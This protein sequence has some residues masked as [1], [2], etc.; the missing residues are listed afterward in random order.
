MSLGTGI[1]LSTL[2]IA[3]VALYG[4]TKD[5]WNWRRFVKRSVFVCFGMVLLGGMAGGAVYFYRQLPTVVGRQTEYA[6]LRLGM[7]RDEVLYVNGYP[8][9]VLAD[10][11]D[12]A[13]TGFYVVV[14]TS[15]LE[16]GKTIH[17]YSRW[18][19]AG[20]NHNINVAFN[21]AK[22]VAAIHCFSKDELR[23]CPAIAG[24]ADGD[25]EPEVLR[26]FGNNPVA[27]ITG[28]TKSLTYPE[29][30][31]RLHLAKQRVYALEVSSPGYVR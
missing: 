10:D 17:D 28:T 12:P 30:G 3:L 21:D 8:P 18:S 6:G 29:I 27:K 20:Y 11:L 14:E 7:S 4:I 9:S 25:Y 5:R 24:I 2:V 15:K 19:Y 23:R 31:V 26:A 16:K 1:F 22:T 13:W